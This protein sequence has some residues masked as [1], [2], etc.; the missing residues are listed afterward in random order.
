MKTFFL[1]KGD[2]LPTPPIENWSIVELLYLFD[3]QEQ[4]GDAD[5]IEKIR[6]LIKNKAHEIK[7]QW[8][9]EGQ[10]CCSEYRNSIRLQYERFKKIINEG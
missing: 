10:G 9:F 8:D 3:L 6:G 4:S 5:Y 2:T 1:L 7:D